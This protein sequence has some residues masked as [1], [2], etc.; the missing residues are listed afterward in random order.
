MGPGAGESRSGGDEGLSR[1]LRWKTKRK[2]E[3]E[4][5]SGADGEVVGRATSVENDQ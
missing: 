1:S 4:S 5:E 2:K 3:W